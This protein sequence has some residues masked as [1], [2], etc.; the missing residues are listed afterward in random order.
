MSLTFLSFFKFF[1]FIDFK[2]YCIIHNI[3]IP[4]SEK[5]VFRRKRITSSFL[6][7]NV[8]FTCSVMTASSKSTPFKRN[9]YHHLHQINRPL[10]H[11]SRIYGVIEGGIPIIPRPPQKEYRNDCYLNCKANENN[12]I[13]ISYKQNIHKHCHPS[14]YYHPDMRNKSEHF[15]DC[16]DISSQYIAKPPLTTIREGAMENSES[17]L[18]RYSFA[19]LEYGGNSF[20]T[21]S[22]KANLTKIDRRGNHLVFEEGL[23]FSFLEMSWETSNDEKY[24]NSWTEYW[25]DEVGAHYYFN[26]ESG[27]ASWVKPD[28]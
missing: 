18:T 8:L 13:K 26:I 16:N 20:S 22:D 2:L 25:D 17:G 7:G 12:R 11:L 21:E 6:Q 1:Y 4:F 9:A 28:D 23:K 3:F 5:N 14:N 19:S 24:S 10:P 15:Q 27:E